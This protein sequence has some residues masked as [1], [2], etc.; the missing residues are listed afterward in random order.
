MLYVLFFRWALNFFFGVRGDHGPLYEENDIGMPRNCPQAYLEP[1]EEDKIQIYPL[2]NCGKELSPHICYKPKKIPRIGSC[3]ER[4]GWRQFSDFCFRS[5]AF[6]RFVWFGLFFA[7]S[8]Q[9]TQVKIFT[10]NLWVGF[11]SSVSTIL[12]K[13][14]NQIFVVFVLVFKINKKMMYTLC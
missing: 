12:K 13:V 11:N 7:R 1:F 3:F 5:V 8:K 4:C 10:A 9:E 6:V 2:W 14:I